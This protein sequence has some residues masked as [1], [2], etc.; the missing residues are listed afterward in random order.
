MKRL[1]K[2]NSLNKI[3]GWSSLEIDKSLA[4]AGYG[5]GDDSK[6]TYLQ[7]GV[8]TLDT[9]D[10][11]TG[12]N[13]EQRQWTEG[14]YGPGRYF[15]LYKEEKWNAFLE[16]IHTILQ[17]PIILNVNSDGSIKVWEGNHRIEACRQLGINEIP[18]KVFYMGGS[19][20]NFKIA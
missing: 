5:V 20:E 3:A 18:A 7:Q 13:N 14:K 9:L 4:V 19:Q 11:A 16:N 8:L 12:F 17:D 2:R 1:I 15:G 6:E 10:N